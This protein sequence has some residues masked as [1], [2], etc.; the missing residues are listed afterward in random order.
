MINLRALPLLS[1]ACLLQACASASGTLAPLDAGHPASPQAPEVAIEDPSACLR[2]EPGST[3][4]AA[5][6]GARDA[7]PA[8]AYVCPMHPEVSADAPGRCPQ[9]G[10][11]LEPRAHEHEQEGSHGS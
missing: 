3:E 6:A 11:Q 5:P 1:I 4:P 7:A 10:M 8:G 9:C 2:R